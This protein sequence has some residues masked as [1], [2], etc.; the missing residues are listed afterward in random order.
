MSN[1]AHGQISELHACEYIESGQDGAEAQH[2]SDKIFPPG[3]NNDDVQ[4]FFEK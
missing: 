1:P 4:T 3:R 2:S